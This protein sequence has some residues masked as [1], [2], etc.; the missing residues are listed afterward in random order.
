M[1]W[2]SKL[3]LRLRSLFRSRSVE[4]DLTEELQFHLE[5]L[6]DDYVAAGASPRDARYAALREMGAIE[7]RKEECRDARGLRLIS[8]L[9]GDLRY[10]LRQ[11]RKYP[12]F[13]AAAV[14]TIALGIG[15]NATMATVIS[16]VFRPL[17]VG[18]ADRLTILATTVSANPRIWQRLAYPE[19]SGLQVV[20]GG[21]LRHGGLG[22]EAGG[23]DGGRTDRPSDG[24]GRFRE[25]L[26]HSPT[27]SSGGTADSS[28]RRRAGWHATHCCPQ[29]FVLDAPV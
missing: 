15:P 13:T 3:R 14:L 23:Y 28:L 6:I 20:A 8:A 18:D 19:S 5:H 9:H 7:A 10:S 1:R 26:L 27:R 22:L 11:L 24:N 4:Q 17:P 25:L 2:T 12:V 16:S 29:P 21:V